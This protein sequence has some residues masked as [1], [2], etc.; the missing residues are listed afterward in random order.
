MGAGRRAAGATKG[1]VARKRLDL[2]SEIR[3]EQV[4]AG[5]LPRMTAR[6]LDEIGEAEFEARTWNGWGR[7]VCGGCQTAMSDNGACL[8]TDSRTP[9]EALLASLGIAVTVARTKPPAQAL[10]PPQDT[11]VRSCV[12]EHAV[13]VARVEAYAAERVLTPR[14]AAR[15]LGHGDLWLGTMGR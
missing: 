11:R 1:S 9:E 13:L 12:T 4:D 8:C 7:T 15:A 5:I 6:K 2:D 14:E 3:R 10:T